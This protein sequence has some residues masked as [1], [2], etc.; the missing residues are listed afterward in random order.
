MK[1]NWNI[2]W[3]RNEPNRNRERTSYDWNMTHS[4]SPEQKQQR[5]NKP[6]DYTRAYVVFNISSCVGILLLIVYSAAFRTTYERQLYVVE[7][8]H[9]GTMYVMKLLLKPPTID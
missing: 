4:A 1:C 3:N 9:T 8:E 5:I 6:S 7:I 2:E